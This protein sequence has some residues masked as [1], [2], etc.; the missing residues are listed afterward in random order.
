MRIA[1]V[2]VGV[3]EINQLNVPMSTQKH[4]VRLEVVVNDA[5]AAALGLGLTVRLQCS[6]SAIPVRSW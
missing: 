2:G 1:V 5:V 6:Y 4:V 3:T